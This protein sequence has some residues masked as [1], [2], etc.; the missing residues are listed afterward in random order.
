MGT[1]FIVNLTAIHCCVSGMIPYK[2]LNEA[3]SYNAL[4]LKGKL[5]TDFAIPEATIKY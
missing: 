4:F 1:Q 5:I 2:S 3:V